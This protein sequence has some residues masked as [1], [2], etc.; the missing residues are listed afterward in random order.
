M[1][2]RIVEMDATEPVANDM[3]RPPEDAP[4]LWNDVGCLP[5]DTQSG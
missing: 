5:A 2:E 1:A 4:Q 3:M